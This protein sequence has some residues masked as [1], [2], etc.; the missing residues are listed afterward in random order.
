MWSRGMF[1]RGIRGGSVKQL[2]AKRKNEAINFLMTPPPP[3]KAGGNENYEIISIPRFATIAV[4]S[5]PPHP[6]WKSTAA[7]DTTQTVEMI[8]S[9]SRMRS[10]TIEADGIELH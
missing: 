2:V 8:K 7:G 6:L 4:R 9:R 3:R 1:F 10:G 5:P